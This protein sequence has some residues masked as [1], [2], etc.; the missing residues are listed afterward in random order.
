MAKRSDPVS[1]NSASNAP[2]P[3]ERPT[4]AL[5]SDG[6]GSVAGFVATVAVVAVVTTARLVAKL[7]NGLTS[8]G[9]LAAFFRQG[10]DEIG[11]ALKAFPDAI[12]TQEPGTVLNP[13]QGE[14]ASKRSKSKHSGSYISFSNRPPWPSEIAREPKPKSDH[15]HD[16]GHQNGHSM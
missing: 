16:H 3:A 14:I 2:G 10:A 15:G 11:Q 6:S 12:Q 13:T 1:K 5:A 4:A 8:D 9:T 7:W